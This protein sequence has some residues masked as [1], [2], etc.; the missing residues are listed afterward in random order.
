MQVP[1]ITVKRTPYPSGRW[2]ERLSSLPIPPTFVGGITKRAVIVGSAV[3]S[4]NASGG[5]IHNIIDSRS[6]Y[7]EQLN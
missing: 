2:M 5:D 6:R 1:Y 3:F 4:R 7:P